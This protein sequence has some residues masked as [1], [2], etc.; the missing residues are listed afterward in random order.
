M[1]AARLLLS[2]GLL[3]SLAV[4]PTT[5]GVELRK[6]PAHI[7]DCYDADTCTA[8]FDLGLNIVMRGQKVR[9]YGIDAWEMRGEEKPKGELAKAWMNAQVANKDVVLGLVQKKKGGDKTGKYGRWLV[10]VFVGERNLNE[11]LVQLG[12]AEYAEY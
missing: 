4:A 2:A 7:Q 5:D 10:I 11:E 6:Y 9:L 12:H 1:E 3:V 8:D